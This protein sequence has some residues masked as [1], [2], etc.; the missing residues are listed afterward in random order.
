LASTQTHEDEGAGPHLQAD[1]REV[2]LAHLPVLPL[3]HPHSQ[4]RHSARPQQLRGRTLDHF[5]VH[6][7]KKKKTT[8]KRKR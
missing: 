4:S 6:L 3:A 5:V 7:V 2:A 1:L 8:K